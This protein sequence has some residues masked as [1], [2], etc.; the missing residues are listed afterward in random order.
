MVAI[1]LLTLFQAPQPPPAKPAVPAPTTQAPRPRPAA[2]ASS[3]SLTFFISDSSGKLLDD[4]TVTLTGPVDRERKTPPGA[5]LRITGLRS[6]TYRARFARDGFSTF[7]RTITLRRSDEIEVTLSAAPSPPPSSP[8]SPTPAPAPPPATPPATPAA[9]T[10]TAGNLPRTGTPKTMSLPDFIEKNFISGREAH[11][12]NV[13][14]CSGVAQAVVWQVREPWDGRQ[15]ESADG[16]LYVIGGEGGIKID[17]REIGVTAG[18]FA[19]VP[20]GTP[21][22]FTRRGR[23][24]LIVLA[25]LAGAPCAAE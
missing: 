25:V 23:N 14:G 1:L 2:A 13:V 7:E 16:M 3:L 24:P 8:S 21:Y 15:H 5:A 19:V 22:G 9:A 17:G 12:E 6:G 11:K 4:V 10:A 18:S 20:R